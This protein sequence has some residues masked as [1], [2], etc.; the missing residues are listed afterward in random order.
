MYRIIL[1]PQRPCDRFRITGDELLSS[2]IYAGDAYA[3]C[4]MMER[5]LCAT[6]MNVITSYFNQHLH[7]GFL[8][9][10]RARPRRIQFI[11]T[12]PTQCNKMAVHT[13]HCDSRSSTKSCPIGPVQ[14]LKTHDTSRSLCPVASTSSLAYARTSIRER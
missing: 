6:L 11:Y 1:E 13:W 4:P 12:A 14:A 2:R 3:S 7:F 8:Q 5:C 9:L 10:L